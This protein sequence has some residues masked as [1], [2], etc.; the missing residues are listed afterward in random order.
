[1][2]WLLSAGMSRH[3]S[4]DRSPR[5]LNAKRREGVGEREFGTREPSRV[6]LLMNS[7]IVRAYRT[8]LEDAVGQR[9]MLAQGGYAN[10]WLGF[11]TTIRNP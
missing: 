3:A 9:R 7:S 4:P 10:G 1:M 11:L 6:C 8:L 2:W 5:C